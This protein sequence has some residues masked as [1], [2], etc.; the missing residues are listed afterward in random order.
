MTS[1]EIPLCYFTKE[2]QEIVEQACDID[3]LNLDIF[4]PEIEIIPDWTSSMYLI[5]G[6]EPFNIRQFYSL[7]DLERY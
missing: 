1:P 4:D 5:A 7:T 6:D 3:T 2:E